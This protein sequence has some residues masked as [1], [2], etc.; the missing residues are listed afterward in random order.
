[1]AQPANPHAMAPSRPGRTR[2]A[3]PRKPG[4]WPSSARYRTYLA[5]DLTGLVYLLMGFAI[6]GA[7]RALANGPDAWSA[8][9][10]SYAHPLWILFHLVA[11]VSVIF[12]G[13]RFF[14]LFPKAQPARIGPA[15]PPPRPVLQAMLYG[16]WIGATIVLVAILAGGI[17]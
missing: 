8:L 16:A 14:R 13:V 11:L 10:A 3:A 7:A 5:F 2:T 4:N 15:K 12:V 1:M 6:L 17:P 9:L